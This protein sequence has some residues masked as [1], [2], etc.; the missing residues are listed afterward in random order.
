MTEKTRQTILYVTGAVVF[1]GI[2]FA[3]NLFLVKDESEEYTY[4]Y[5]IGSTYSSGPDGAELLYRLFEGLGLEPV[6]HRYPLLEE[7]MPEDGTDVIWHVSGNSYGD[8]GFEDGEIDW[9]DEYVYGGGRLVLISNPPPERVA[10]L[11]ADDLDN[12]DS[13][14]D[15]WL[16]KIDLYPIFRDINARAGSGSYFS[17]SR[18]LPILFNEYRGLG[19][20]GEV[21]TY[22]RRGLVYPMV[23]RLTSKD[24]SSGNARHFLRDGYGS[25]L[26]MLRHGSGQVWFVSD[27]YLFSNLLIQEADNAILATNLILGTR[28]WGGR[29]VLFDE[30][31]LGF[32]RTRSLADAARTPL[33][34]AIIYLG[35]LVALGLGVAGARFGP[36][37]K[38]EGAVGVSQRAFVRALAGLWH[39]ANA[40]T[41]A[42]DSLWKRY[43]TKKDV[44]R[45]GFSDELDLMR[46]GNPREDDLLDIARKLDS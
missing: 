45:R 33:G 32:T 24:I 14:L 37:R 31:H 44:R 10:T 34:R 12:S 23:Y 26:V 35:L 15:Y 11:P 41:A 46:K 1:I 13:L 25:V 20:V 21:N 29:S 19:E 42:A 22:V 7:F 30:Y 9:V 36:V 43:H 8:P 39:G 28:N 2:M 17:N 18:R 5:P 16:R 40:R 3:I 38:S 4:D 27:P 6:R